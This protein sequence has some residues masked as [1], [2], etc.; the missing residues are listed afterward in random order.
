MEHQPYLKSSAQ[1]GADA[2]T[3]P[4]AQ[5]RPSKTACTLGVGPTAARI[6]GCIARFASAFANAASAAV[7]TTRLRCSSRGPKPTVASLNSTAA[8]TTTRDLMLHERSPGYGFEAVRRAKIGGG[9]PE[10]RLWRLPIYPSRRVAQ[11][12]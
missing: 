10:E 3:C 12:V 5:G 9:P 8:T 7:E 6:R 4:R 1:N 11:E 2:E